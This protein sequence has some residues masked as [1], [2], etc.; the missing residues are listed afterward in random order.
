VVAVAIGCV[1]ASGG[2]LPVD[3][4]HGEVVDATLTAD[5]MHLDDVRVIQ[6][7]RRLRFVV[8]ALQVP[9]VYQGGKGQHFQGHAP[10]QRHLLRLVHHSHA[11]LADLAQDA[12]I[13]QRFAQRRDGRRGR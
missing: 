9:R 6:A 12:E 4:L 5:G 11:A 2:R 7:G 1:A 8:K 3:E 10:P 13:A